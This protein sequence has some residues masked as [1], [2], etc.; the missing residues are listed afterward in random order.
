V[1]REASITYQ[2]VADA[3]EALQAEGIHPSARSIRE[4]LGS[5]SMGTI[6]RFLNEWKATLPAA[7]P[8][9]PAPEPV[10]VTPQPAPLEPGPAPLPDP[11]PVKR[12]CLTTD[13]RIVPAADHDALHTQLAE[14][15]SRWA[16]AQEELTQLRDLAERQRQELAWMK[17]QLDGALAARAFA[18][19]QVRDV[20]TRLDEAIARAER[21]EVALAQSVPWS[22]NVP[23]PA[24]FRPGPDHP[25]FLPLPGTD[26][27]QRF[28]GL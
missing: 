27:N 4:R 13:E 23:G 16:A 7:D 22:A 26:P 17:T 19:A 5:G 12:N 24:G 10:P 28:L 9:P 11:A 2:Q 14:S 21:A 25:V 20:Q 8:V 18:E 3:A 1:G 15:E 6:Q